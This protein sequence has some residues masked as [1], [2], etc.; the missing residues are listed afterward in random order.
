MKYIR[1]ML[2]FLGYV[3]LASFL[4]H[5]QNKFQLWAAVVSISLAIFTERGDK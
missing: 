2:L 1:V 3:N 4:W 5:E